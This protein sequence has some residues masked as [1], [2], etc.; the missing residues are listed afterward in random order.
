MTL[1]E[2]VAA[3]QRAQGLLLE[4]VEFLPPLALRYLLQGRLPVGL[5]QLHQIAEPLCL[6]L[7]AQLINHPLKSMQQLQSTLNRDVNLFEVWAYLNKS[8]PFLFQGLSTG[9]LHEI[10]LRLLCFYTASKIRFLPQSIANFVVYIALSLALY[11]LQVIR[12]HQMDTAIFGT[13]QSVC[14]STNAIFS[15]A[16]LPGFWAGACVT[17]AND[18]F[19]FL[20]VGIWRSIF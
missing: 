18:S 17:A 7:L 3:K 4:L 5:K 6:S 19:C 15:T 13:S 12:A 1:P 14:Q 20:C 9:I 16:G 10:A 2:M 11:P 8:P